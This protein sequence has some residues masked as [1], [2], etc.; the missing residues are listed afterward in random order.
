[1]IHTLEMRAAWSSL[2][3]HLPTAAHR[4]RGL[5]MGLVLPRKV[6]LCAAGGLQCRAVQGYCASD[7]F[8]VVSLVISDAERQLAQR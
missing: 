7:C 3:I 4:S 5:G 1:M 2:A 8:G 6:V